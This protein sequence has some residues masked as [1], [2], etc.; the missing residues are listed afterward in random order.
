LCAIALQATSAKAALAAA[1]GR[2]GAKGNNPLAGSSFYPVGL[3]LYHLYLEFLATSA[4][5]DLAAAA[6]CGLCALPQGTYFW[7]REQLPFYDN[8]YGS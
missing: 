5:A 8:Q 6:G 2:A 1:A 4:K 3:C 7:L